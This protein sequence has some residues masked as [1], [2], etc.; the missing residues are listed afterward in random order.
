MNLQAKDPG[1]PRIVS[2][3]KRLHGPIPFTPVERSCGVKRQCQLRI[4]YP[5]ARQL[6]HQRSG[7]MFHTP[8]PALSHGRLAFAH[9]VLLAPFPFAFWL[10]STNGRHLEEK[11]RKHEDG[12]RRRQNEIRSPPLSDQE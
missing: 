7:G 6:Q 1:R 2:V 5:C 12:R 10:D 9:C 8:H 11:F 4:N 3:S